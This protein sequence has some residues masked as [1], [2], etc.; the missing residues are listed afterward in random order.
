MFKISETRAIRN[1]LYDIRDLVDVVFSRAL[2]C[3]NAA[4]V[5]AGAPGSTTI[6]KRRSR[7]NRRSPQAAAFSGLERET[8]SVIAISV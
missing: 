3:R 2:L 7:L 6:S 4:R 1:R 8:S 5:E